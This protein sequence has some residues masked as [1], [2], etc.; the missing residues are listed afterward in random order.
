VL[1]FLEQAGILVQ[2]EIKK[3]LINL[4]AESKVHHVSNGCDGQAYERH[5]DEYL[6]K[7]MLDYPTRGGKKARAGLVLLSCQLFGGNIDQALA[8]AVAYEFL[9]NFALIH[10]DIEDGSLMRRGKKTLHR[11]SG[12]P[13]AI[14]TGDSMLALVF[15]TL[16]SNNLL[17]GERLT[18]DIMSYF[19]TVIQQ[20]LEGQALELGWTAYDVMPTRKEYETMVG[21]KTGWYSG[22]GPCQC[23]ALIAGASETQRDLLGKFGYALGVGFQV[24]D[25]ILNLITGEYKKEYRENACSK[26]ACNK[27]ECTG[28]PAQ[29]ARAYGKELGG[30]IAEGKRTLIV[31]EMLERLSTHDAQRVRDIL[32]KPSDKTTEEEIMWVVEQAKTCGALDVAIKYCKRQAQ[33]AHDVLKRLVDNPHDTQTHSPIDTHV[34]I[35]L[36]ELI[37]FLAIE[38]MH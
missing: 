23:G 33:E 25:D 4:H 8:S 7:H 21:K 12:I 30:D 2:D 5:L 13:L 34:I 27:K 20:T 31:I 9:Q 28:G 35:L 38:R 11:I 18:F 22:K 17:L 29:K 19:H 37:S 16:L 24:R 3:R 32:C 15:K 10:D 26:N 6:Y 36:E 14:N 1:E